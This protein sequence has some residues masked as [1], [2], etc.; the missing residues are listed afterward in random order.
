MTLR[1]AGTCPHLGAAVT[2]LS[3]DNRLMALALFL[4]ACGEGLFIYLQPL[5]VQ[6]LGANPVQ[7]GGVLSLAGFSMAA[8]FLPGGILADRVSRKKMMLAGWGLGLVAALVMAAARD[9]REFIPGAMLYTFSAFCV[10]A[11]NATIADAADGAPLERVLTLVYAGFWAGSIVSP[12]VGGWLARLVEMRAIYVVAA[13][14][15]ALSTTVVLMIKPQPARARMSAWQMPS[16]QSLR[17]SVALGVIVFAVFLAMYI[18]QPLAPN[19]LRDAGW[20]V[21]R[22]GLIGSLHALGVTVLSP[23]IGRWS[24]TASRKLGGLL[25]G[26][27]LVWASLGLLLVG[28]RAMPGLALGGFFMRGGYGACRNLTSAHIAGRVLPEN[29]GAAFGLAET[30]MASAQMVAPYLA[31]WLYSLRPAAPIWVGLALVPVTM[32]FTPL[33]SRR[34]AVMGLANGKEPEEI[35]A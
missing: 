28:A 4:W 23:T 5:Y 31:G 34:P 35:L 29:R 12:W 32:L 8:S 25:M 13:M 16:V 33:L 9:W 30:S 3:R 27:S 19:F 14:C 18:G 17:S 1:S 10:P 11:I 26:Q 2:E 6:Q 24:A 21:E 22:I 7:I 15:F 20:P